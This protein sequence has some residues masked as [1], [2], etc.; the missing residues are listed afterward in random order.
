MDLN[1]Q[2]DLRVTSSQMK[3]N[4]FCEVCM[5]LN[6]SNSVFGSMLLSA[7]LISPHGFQG[8]VTP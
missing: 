8:S 3:L 1:L 7:E 6:S 4:R 2:E 5:D